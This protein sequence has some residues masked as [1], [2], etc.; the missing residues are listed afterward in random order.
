MKTWKTLSEREKR[1]RL[2]GSRTAC[3]RLLEKAL[4]KERI[5]FK[6]QA[7]ATIYFVDF[8][9]LPTRLAVEVDGSI[10]KEKRVSAKDKKR[11]ELL[12]SLGWDILRFSNEEV[13]ADMPRVIERIKLAQFWRL[14]RRT[15]EDLEKQEALRVGLG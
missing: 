10:H 1:K 4:K 15:P 12:R 14:P 9:I 7:P 5:K 3:E 2:I 6:I 8:Q 13:I 11:T